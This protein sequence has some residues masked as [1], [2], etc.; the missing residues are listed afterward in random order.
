M[1]RNQ[2]EHGTKPKKQ[3]IVCDGQLM[4]VVMGSGVKLLKIEDR[5]RKKGRGNGKNRREQRIEKEERF[6][7]FNSSSNMITPYNI[8]D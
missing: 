6:Q 7:E 8:Y 2:C 5:E 3:M 4:R 1:N